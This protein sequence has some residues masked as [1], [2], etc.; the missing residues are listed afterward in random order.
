M[1]NVVQIWP[2]LTVCKQVTVCPGHIWTTL[3]FPKITS[4]YEPP[5]IKLQ[6]GSEWMHYISVSRTFFGGGTPK[7]IA[8]MP[9]NPW[10]WIYIYEAVVRARRLLQYFQ[11]PDKN[12]RDISRYIY[13]FLERFKTVIYVFI[14]L[15]LLE[16]QTVF[17]GTPSSA[18]HSLKKTALSNTQLC[19]T[20]S[21]FGLSL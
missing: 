13:N 5:L 8:H 21:V 20:D 10:L 1:C 14:P 11:L 18:E 4:I 7:I 19:K 2:G 12:S 17:C 16:P 3:Y 9:R 6:R 15:I